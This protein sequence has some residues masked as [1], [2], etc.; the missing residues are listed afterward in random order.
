MLPHWEHLYQRLNYTRRVSQ[1]DLTLVSCIHNLLR[2]YNIAQQWLHTCNVHKPTTVQDQGV[3]KVNIRSH[4]VLLAC[5]V[6][7]A[8]DWLP[9]PPWFSQAEEHVHSRFCMS[10]DH[11]D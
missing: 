10:K 2:K 11:S 3:Y 9:A 4:V 6:A 7:T 5:V 8:S 1:L